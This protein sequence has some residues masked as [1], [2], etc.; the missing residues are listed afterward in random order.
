MNKLLSITNLNVSI[1]EKLILKGITLDINPG[2]LHAIM[3]PNGSGKSSMAY[4]LMGHPKYNVSSG[5]IFFLNDD[6]ESLSVDVRAKKG[7]FLAFQYP[8]EIEGVKLFDFLRQSY[9]AIYG[10][11]DKQIGLKDFK[12]LVDTKLKLLNMNPD[13]VERFVNYGFS[14]GEKKKAEML[15][16]AVI[17]PKL[18]ILDEIDSGLDIDAL[19]AVCDVINVLKKESSI[20]FLVITHYKRILDYIKPDFVHIL[21]DGVI[22]QSGDK[23]LAT[24]LESYG[25]AFI[26]KNDSL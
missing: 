17:Q 19:R 11:T 24:K 2:E 15:Q 3:G 20:S 10:G 7:I 18:A 22:V 6:L 13:F 1:E 25:Y 5:K 21:Q 16:L 14:G 8:Q 9:N 23:S 12:K 4:T 26:N